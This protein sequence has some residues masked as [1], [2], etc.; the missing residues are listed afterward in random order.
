MGEVTDQVTTSTIATTAKNT[1]PT[2]SNHLS[3]QW[4]CSAIRE[5]QQPIS[6]SWNFGHRLV[7][8][9]WYIR[10]MDTRFHVDISCPIDFHVHSSSLFFICIIFAINI[11]KGL[12]S[13]NPR[14]ELTKKPQESSSSSSSSTSS[15]SSSSS[16]AKAANKSDRP[17]IWPCTAELASSWLGLWY[18]GGLL[19]WASCLVFA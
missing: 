11:E 17:F 18:L 14:K 2:C 3:V 7:R 6:P 4:I 16:E 13:E 9:Y 1:A 15:S 12:E 8:Y 19:R 10:Y 5:S